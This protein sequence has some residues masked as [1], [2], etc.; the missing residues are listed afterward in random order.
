MKCE[1]CN[2]DLVK[3][4]EAHTK[5]EEPGTY[6]RKCGTDLDSDVVRNPNYENTVVS[7]A[8]V[9]D[10]LKRR[11]CVAMGEKHADGYIM[12][13]FEQGAKFVLED[14]IERLDKR[15]REAY[16]WE[17]LEMDVDVPLKGV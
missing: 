12:T 5:T 2:G 9:R 16:P 1:T 8:E 4:E 13:E 17:S 15:E 7:L 6:C 14:L 3:F 10:L 11:I